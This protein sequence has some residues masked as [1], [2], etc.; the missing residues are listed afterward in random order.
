MTN[1]IKERNERLSGYTHQELVDAINEHVIM[2]THCQRNREILMKHLFYGYTYEH[3]A[4]E[5]GMSVRGVKYAYDKSL[6]LLLKNL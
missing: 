4:E 6:N 2:H 3:L 1:R 5:Y